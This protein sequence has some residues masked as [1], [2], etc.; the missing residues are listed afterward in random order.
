MLFH[1]GRWFED[2]TLGQGSEQFGDMKGLGFLVQM[3]AQALK[4]ANGVLTKE[5]GH[6][7]A[8]GRDKDLT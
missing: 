8:P 6:L 2:A 5:D 4:P 7:T 1:G 3:A